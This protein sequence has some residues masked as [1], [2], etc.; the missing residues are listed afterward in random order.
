MRKAPDAQGKTRRRS[1]EGS[2]KDANKWSFAATSNQRQWY[3][4]RSRSLQFVV[5]CTVYPVNILTT[6]I[7]ERLW[8]LSANSHVPRDMQSERLLLLREGNDVL[9]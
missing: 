9:S 6:D 7:I 4:A 1:G 5:R 3:L 8:Q 2:D